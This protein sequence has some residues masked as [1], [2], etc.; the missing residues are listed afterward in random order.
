MPLPEVLPGQPSLLN[1]SRQSGNGMP[2]PG[3]LPG[4]PSL[5]NSSRQSGNEMP[6]PGV[7]LGQS[8]LLNTSRQ[9]GNGMPLPSVLP[10]Q[11]SLLTSDKQPALGAT[12]AALHQPTLAGLQ[13]MLHDHNTFVQ[14]FKQVMDMPTHDLPQWEVVIMVDGNVDKRRYNAPTAPEVAGLLPGNGDE[15]VRGRDI[16]VRARGG[17][18]WRISGLHPAYDPL[19][20]PGMTHAPVAP[21]RRRAVTIEEEGDAGHVVADTEPAQPAQDDDSEEEGDAEH[22]AADAGPTQPA[23][24]KKIT[25]R[26]WACYHMHDRNPTSHTLFVY[27]KRLYQEWIVDQY[28]KGPLRAA[29]YGGVADAVANN[30]ANIDNLGRLIVLPSSFTAGQRHMAQLY[31]DSMAI[32]R[33]YGKPDLFI[34]MTCNPK[35]EEIVSALKPGEIANDRPDLVTRLLKKGVFGEVKRGLPHA[36]ILLILHSDDKPRGP[37]EYN[38]MVS[39]ELPDKNAHPTLFE[40]VT[41]CMVHGPCG[42]INPHCTCMAD[43]VCSKGYPKAFTEHTTDTTGSYPTYRRRDDGRTFERGGFA[44]DNRWVVPYNPYLSLFFN[45][46]INVEV[47]SSVAAVKYLYKY[48]YKGHDRAQVDVGPVDAAA[49]DGTAPAQPRMRDEIKIYQDGRYVSTSEASHRMYGFD[50]HKEH[51][52]V[53][54]LGTDVAAI[55]NRNPHTTLTAWFAFNK[56]AREHLN[57]S[58][59]LRLAL[60]TLYH[61]FPQIATWK[62]KEKQWALRTRTPSLLPVGR[63]YFVQPSEGE[64]YFLRF[65]LHHV[66]GATSFEDLTC[67]NRH[68]QHPTQHASFKEACQQRGLLQDDAEWAQCMEEAASMAN[69]SCLR[70]LF[71]ALLVFND[72]ANPLA[73]WERFKEDMAEDFFTVRAQGRVAI[74]VASSSIAALLLDGGRT[75]HSHFKIPVQD[76][77]STSTC[78]INRDSDLAAL[79]QAAALIMWDEAV[80]MHMHVFEAVNRSLQDIMAVINPTFKFLPFGGLVVVF[81]GDFRQILP[82]VPRGTRGDVVKAALNRSSIW[83]HVRVFKLYTNMRMQRLLAQGDAYAQVDATRLQAFADYLQRV[84]EGVERVY[85]SVDLIKEVYGALSSIVEYAARSAYIIERAILTPLNENV[86]ALNKLINDTYAFTKHDGSPAQHRVYY[87]ADS[88]M[89]GDQHGIYPTE[90]LNTLNFPGVPPHELHL[91][92]G[93]PIILLRNMTNGLANG[94]RLIVIQL[95]QHVIEAEVATGPFPVRPAFAM[96]I[97]KAQGQ[98][99]KMVGI[100]LPKPVFTH[101]QLYVAMSRIGCPEG[102]K[103]LVTDGWENAHEDAPAGVYTRNVVYT[104]VL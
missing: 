57:P 10:G 16:R 65:L 93:C 59:P 26:E 95:M 50:L 89:H 96:T 13:Q 61:D 64:R 25:A 22:V 1:T 34:T 49:L 43:G 23:Q 68:L 39:A 80:M 98:T 5:L 17:G 29:I 40:V 15:P 4:Q 44:F 100:F 36:H 87:S 77:N 78:Y 99:L 85:P 12:G 97:N 62:K 63:M 52:N 30:D 66:P 20:F 11:P 14:R 56:T 24:R 91:Q 92:E 42:T 67:T 47:C 75:A 84:G 6:L 48:V 19:H 35:W 104:E 79:L 53:V 33:Q 81:G 37:D 7:L 58:A 103:M 31:Q 72:V 60:N 55:L 83:Q 51:P 69:A 76:L 90:F 38:R 41:R 88:V 8:S 73:L 102:V 9:S 54:R 71:A 27:G 32:V 101:G 21:V 45:C 18:L 28:S 74:V 46:H 86:D 94:T 2:L 82:V 3:V 70:A